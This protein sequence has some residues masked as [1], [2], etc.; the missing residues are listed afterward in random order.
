MQLICSVLFY[1]A[2][3]D[4]TSSGLKLSS[5]TVSDELTAAVTVTNFGKTTGKE[6]VELYLSASAKLDK[7]GM[8][9]KAFSTTHLFKYIEYQTFTFTI[10]T[11]SGTASDKD[12]FLG[13]PCRHRHLYTEDWYIADREAFRTV[14]SELV[15]KP[16][17]KNVV[18]SNS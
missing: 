16:D 1:K 5:P 7:P 15:S 10:T 18:E 3:S 14:M 12:K 4:F 2:N 6:D 13:A 9:L 8:E 17:G 11:H